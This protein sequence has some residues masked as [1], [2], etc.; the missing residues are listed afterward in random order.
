MSSLTGCYQSF[1]C[2][3]GVFSPFLSRMFFWKFSVHLSLFFTTKRCNCTFIFM[4]YQYFDIQLTKKYVTLF[5]FARFEE[6]LSFARHIRT[7]RRN[8]TYK[9]LVYAELSTVF[10][11]I[12]MYRLIGY[13]VH[14]IS[15]IYLG[16][17][18][19]WP[20]YR[21]LFAYF[22]ICHSLMHSQLLGLYY[23]IKCL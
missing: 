17:T 2:H 12:N 14:W 11:T 13:T 5:L 21:L 6:H 7:G 1:Y 22:L 16:S 3:D 15:A 20:L 8:S 19:F 4:R 23:N 10:T 18:N 9:V